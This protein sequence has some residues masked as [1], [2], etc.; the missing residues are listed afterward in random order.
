MFRCIKNIVYLLFMLPL[1]VGCSTD[2]YLGDTSDDLHGELPVEFHFLLPD[3]SSTRGF[4]DKEVKTKFK[5]GDLIH[6]LG[7]FQTE[8][9]QE[10]GDAKKT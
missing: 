8:S 5:E 6:I 9:L 3:V 7:T 4:D 10:N 1:L 2:L